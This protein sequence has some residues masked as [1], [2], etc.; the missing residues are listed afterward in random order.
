MFNAEP[1]KIGVPVTMP[2]LKLNVPYGIT[3]TLGVST[4]RFPAL[5]KVVGEVKSRPFLIVKLPA[6]TLLL[7]PD[8]ALVFDSLTIC[9]ETPS[10]TMVAA[11]VVMAAPSN[12]KVPVTL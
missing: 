7:K 1:I 10:S 8:R 9:E 5:V 4:V 3:K 12:F 11:F 6:A 2:P